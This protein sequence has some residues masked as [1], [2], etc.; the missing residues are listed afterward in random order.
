MS[1][2][3]SSP[4]FIR[5]RTAFIP[6]TLKA[7]VLVNRRCRRSAES[8]RAR[9][10][11]QSGAPCVSSCFL[12]IAVLYVKC[13]P[14]SP[15]P[16]VPPRSPPVCGAV[17]VRRGAAEGGEHRVGGAGPLRGPVDLPAEPRTGA[18]ELPERRHVRLPDPP[19]FKTL[20]GSAMTRGLHVRAITR[21]GS[22]TQR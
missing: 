16:C 1:R 10:N 3:E 4:F 22:V 2:S 5:G 21:N 6:L 14:L 7:I 19:Y 18:Q 8:R 12:E 15:P 13:Q 20:A 9:R 17:A 11:T